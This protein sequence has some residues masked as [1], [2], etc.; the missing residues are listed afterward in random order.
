M[1]QFEA[2]IDVGVPALAPELATK[3][4]EENPF[5]SVEKAEAV[6]FLTIGRR[7]RQQ[8]KKYCRAGTAVRDRT[9]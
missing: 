3:S 6:F 1:T 8:P 2:A 4:P 9:P 7:G 5:W